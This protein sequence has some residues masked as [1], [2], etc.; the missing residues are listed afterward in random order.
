MRIA[1]D[2]AML[3]G[4]PIEEMPPAVAEAGYRHLE[5]PNRDDFIPAFAAV[6]ASREDLAQLRRAVS[7]AGVEIA[8]IAVIQAWSSPDE[9]TRSRAVAW[10]RDGI[11]AAVE[12]GC[13]R[14]NT[15]LSGDP[16]RP[17]E[18][19]TAFR[20]SVDELLPLLEREDLVV[21]AEPHPNDFIE[22]AVAGVDLIRSI[23][24]RRLRYLHCV[25]HAFHLGGTVS[26]QV[27][28]ARGSFDHVHVADTFRPERIIVN[29]QGSRVR[30]HEH[31]DIGQGELDWA[32]V[33]RA[34]RSVEFDG[35]LTVQVFGWEE[36]AAVSFRHNREA[37]ER[38]FGRPQD[39][40]GAG[41]NR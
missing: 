6:R 37:V 36:R 19:A 32:E 40:D 18:C 41:V 22:T 8:S 39:T 15:E 9:D 10:W 12:L 35:V 34:L 21:A 26:S 13:R 25:P 29:P 30:I 31:F 5:L 2:P 4:R 33:A 24:S 7:S 23:G 16:N 14:I 17:D 3:N 1:L 11:A 38:L 20:R 27:E 28:Y